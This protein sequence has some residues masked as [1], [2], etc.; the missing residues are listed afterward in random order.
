MKTL[1]TMFWFASLLGSN[2][3]AVVAEKPY[4]ISCLINKSNYLHVTLR[5]ED[6]ALA[7][8]ELRTADFLGRDD[9]HILTLSGPALH[10]TEHGS[11]LMLS[12]N[13]GR[14]GYVFLR[15]ERKSPSQFDGFVDVS[16]FPTQ[17]SFSTRGELVPMPCFSYER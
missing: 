3:W 15:F 12:Q 7:A 10:V 13:F 11:V 2:A 8:A 1:I 16:Y 9:R 14:S 6:G 4:V 5:A 17:G